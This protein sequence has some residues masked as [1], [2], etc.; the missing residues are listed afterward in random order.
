MAWNGGKASAIER[1][2]ATSSL[3]FELGNKLWHVEQGR[4]P[5]RGSML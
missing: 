5:M 4:E 3:V 2:A 1:T